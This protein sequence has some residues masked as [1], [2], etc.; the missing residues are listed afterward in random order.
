MGCTSIASVCVPG[1]QSR[2]PGAHGLDMGATSPWK[3]PTRTDDR[4]S[5]LNI[6]DSSLVKKNYMEPG[7]FCE[8]MLG[9]DK[10]EH[11]SEG[12]AYVSRLCK[13]IPEHSVYRLEVAA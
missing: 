4:N 11:N 6:S 2:K 7:E 12:R 1:F 8:R 10:L 5:R 13:Y 9:G 3:R